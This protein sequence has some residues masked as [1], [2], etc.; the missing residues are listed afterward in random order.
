MKIEMGILINE[1][2]SVKETS[3]HCRI[4][5]ENY[6]CGLLRKRFGANPLD[7]EETES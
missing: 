2:M 1:Q 3:I 6:F 5:D 4:A 7:F